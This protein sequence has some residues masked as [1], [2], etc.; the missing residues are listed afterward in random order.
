MT[1]PNNVPPQRVRSLNPFEPRAS[2]EF[3]LY[4]M[5]A[6]RRTNS[7]FALD[8]AID[9]AR[10]LERPLVV[11][12]PLRIDYRWASDR[13]HK[14]VIDGMRDNLESFEGTPVE[15]RAYVEP[16]SNAS[17][18]LLRSL[19][20]KT[21][22]IITDDF[23]AFFLRR[24]L[25]A[26]A[27]DVSC[28]VFAVDSCGLL[29]LQAANSAFARAYDF[30]RFLQRELAPHLACRPSASP[31]L[32]GLE[33]L[34]PASLELDG[35]W[36]FET[37]ESLCDEGRI[38][39]LPIDHAVP[40][41]SVNGGQ[42]AANKALEEFLGS[43]LTSYGDG[44]NRVEESATSELSPHLHFGHIGSHEILDRLSALEE[45][46]TSKV[47]DQRSGKRTGWWNM[48]PGAEAFL[49][50]LVTWRELGFN[51]CQHV[52]RHDQY[53]AL[54]AWARK[55]LE[56]HA[57]DQRPYV[58]SL[59]QFDAG[60]TH[61][62]LWNAAQ[63]QL[64]EEGRIHNYLRMLWGKKILH[65]SESPRAAAEIMIELNNRYALDGRDPNSYSGI[66]WT[67]GLFD[68]AWGPERPVFGKIRYMSSANTRRKMK[69]DAYVRRWQPT[70]ATLDFS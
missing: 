68:R 64:R 23:P 9:L 52:A 63:A 44:R 12:E 36:Q 19:A 69:V 26:A 49:D 8:Y 32:S 16:E 3:V 6:T 28:P 34:K 66:F 27:M 33:T 14:F 35:P 60:A 5:I 56:E 40:A 37:K 59:E 62:S 61:D 47:T 30:R 22:A 18:G 65:W 1:S 10:Q 4:W 53:E 38:A 15:Y 50:Q 48:S 46:S 24:M 21:C 11:L 41:V 20:G 51:R 58:Y 42:R 57:S 17:K 70:Q 13:F 7:N 31:N 54:P 29:P 55:T 43:R 39:Q 2:G 67:L 25:Q 45:W